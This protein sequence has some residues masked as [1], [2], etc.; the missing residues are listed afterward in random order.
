MNKIVSPELNWRSGYI[1]M[2]DI[3]G[4][5]ESVSIEYGA[6]F[7]EVWSI[8]RDELIKAK[9]KYENEYILPMTFD[10]LSLSDTLIIGIGFNPEYLFFGDVPIII[11][12]EMLDKLLLTCMEKYHLFFRGA[13]S[14]GRYL[15]YDELNL[16]MGPALD[17]AAAWY[18]TTEWCGVILTPSAEYS[19]EH[20][21]TLYKSK[22]KLK[23]MQLCDCVVKYNIPFKPGLP[24][25]CNYAL[26]WFRPSLREGHDKQVWEAFTTTFSNMVH[27]P[28]YALKYSN[29]LMFVKFI[30]KDTP[31]G[32]KIDSY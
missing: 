7:I 24:Q 21:N 2:L 3:L 17:E 25:V 15:F 5:K 14:Y 29:T 31:I 12:V 23:T 4:F 8:I 18:E 19:Y 10:F 27:L 6:E 11:I 26:V 22:K 13:L 32:K 20:F 30:L 16:A 9:S 28:K 1:L